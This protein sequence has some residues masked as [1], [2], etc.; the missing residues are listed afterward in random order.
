MD[1]AIKRNYQAMAERDKARYE[2]VINFI[3]NNNNQYSGRKSHNNLE[4]ND[5][6]ACL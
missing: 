6:V 4:F 3:N 5:Q 1:P 2:R